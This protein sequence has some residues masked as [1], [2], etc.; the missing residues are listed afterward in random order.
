METP[1]KIRGE[2][3]P[4]EFDPRKKWPECTEVFNN[5][6]DQSRCGDCWAVAAAGALSDRICIH[7]KGK[8]RLSISDID[9]ASCAA[10]LTNQIDGWVSENFKNGLNYISI[11]KMRNIEVLNWSK[12]FI[13]REGYDQK[14]SNSE[15]CI[16]NSDFIVKN[17]IFTSV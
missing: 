7:S 10:E 3:L 4:E 5:I 11:Q 6:R 8:L 1:I 16:K 17:Q 2:D 14:F 12:I 13:F 9:V 15:N